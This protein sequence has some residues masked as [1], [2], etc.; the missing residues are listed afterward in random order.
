MDIKSVGGEDE[1]VVTGLVWFRTE[2]SGG[3]S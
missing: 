1:R 2:K 3:F